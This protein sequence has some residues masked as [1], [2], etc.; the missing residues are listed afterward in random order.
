MS[1]LQPISISEYTEQTRND[2]AA[3]LYVIN[4]T[5]SE[6]VFTV[7]TGAKSQTV[8]VREAWIPQDLTVECPRA[9]LINAPHLRQL[10]SSRKLAIV[11]AT[12]SREKADAGYLGALDVLDTDEG[13]SALAI[14]LSEQNI[15]DTSSLENADDIDINV[16]KKS[17]NKNR[18]M[19]A[20]RENS[21]SAFAQGLIAREASGEDPEGLVN[22]LRNK[23]KNLTSEDF[24]YI[25]E[26]ATSSSIKD[27]AASHIS[28]GESIDL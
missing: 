21:I 22:A 11:G 16:T 18:V 6:I 20:E 2:E 27:V 1:K 13:R 9:A 19:D 3:P 4:R 12:V 7:T 14:L 28:S 15:S 23:A 24:S 17:K 26:Q 10:I 25:A 8:V 5:D